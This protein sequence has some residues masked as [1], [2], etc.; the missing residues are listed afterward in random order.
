MRAVT[1]AARKNRRLPE[2]TP[3]RAAVE[4]R[5]DG[6]QLTEYYV[7]QAAPPPGTPAGGRPRG[8]LAGP[9]SRPGRLGYAARGADRWHFLAADR[10]A[11]G[12]GRTPCRARDPYHADTSRLGSAFYCL[13]RTGRPGRPAR[14]EGIGILRELSD[15]RGGSGFSFVDLSADLSGI[16]FATVVGA[17]KIPLS[18]LEDGFAVADFLPEP[19]GLKEGI[20]WDEFVSSYGYPPDQ[21][22]FQERESLRGRILALPS[23]RGAGQPD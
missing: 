8:I 5:L 9:G 12:A 1:E 21:R 6:D 13:C 2:G 15:S 20:G 11:L 10:V 23:Y 14:A 18:R 19:S 7:R 3:D 22:L 4:A 16:F 17:G